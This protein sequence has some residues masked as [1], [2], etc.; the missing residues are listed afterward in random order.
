MLEA[1]LS[2]AEGMVGSGGG[3]ARRPCRYQRPC[4]R[5]SPAGGSSPFILQPQ[6]GLYVERAGHR[7]GAAGLPRG[8]VHP[9]RRPEGPT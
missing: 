6:L 1:S 4:L 7:V 9:G 3:R 2:L 5:L 8:S